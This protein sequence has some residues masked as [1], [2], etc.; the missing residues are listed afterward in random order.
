MVRDLQLDTSHWLGM[1]FLRGKTHAWSP[2]RPLSEI[3][4]E[5][6]SYTNRVQLKK[7]L[8]AAGLLAY[9]CDGCGIADWRG[10]PLVL[11]LDHLNGV[12]DD[13]RLENLRLLCPNCHSQTST[14]CGKN[15]SRLKARVGP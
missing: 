1:G 5:R 15:M 12:N 13:H 6:S 9:A 2:S 4:V 10:R 3:L 14:F 11:Q 7:R 8:V